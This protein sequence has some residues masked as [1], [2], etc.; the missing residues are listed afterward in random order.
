MTLIPSYN[1]E[2]EN[3]KDKYWIWIHLMLWLLRNME[4]DHGSS[5]LVPTKWLSFSSLLETSY[6]EIIFGHYP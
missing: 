4:K 3:Y 6:H 1:L 5:S 2:I